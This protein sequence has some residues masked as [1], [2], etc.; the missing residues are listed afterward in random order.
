MKA[1][2]GMVKPT[3]GYAHIA[4]SMVAPNYNSASRAAIGVCL[5][6][7]VLWPKMTPEEHLNLFSSIRG[8]DPASPDGKKEIEDLIERSGL[9]QYRNQYVKELSGGNRRKVS[10]VAT[11]IGSPQVIFLDGIVV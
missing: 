6:F 5:Q 8:I 2:F 10:L 4:N 7:D 11:K 3:G 9:Q 1:L